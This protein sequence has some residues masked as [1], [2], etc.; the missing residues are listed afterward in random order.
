MRRKGAFVN[1]RLVT[2]KRTAKRHRTVVETGRG[3]GGVVPQKGRTMRLL[4]LLLSD[5]LHPLD[6]RTDGKARCEMG[7]TAC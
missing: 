5:R 1:A 7:K 6:A 4:R 3:V 2:R